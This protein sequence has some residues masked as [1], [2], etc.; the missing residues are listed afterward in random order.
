VRSVLGVEPVMEPLVFGRLP[1][2]TGELQVALVPAGQECGDDVV[3][4]DR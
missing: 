2:V 4:N 3:C 1:H